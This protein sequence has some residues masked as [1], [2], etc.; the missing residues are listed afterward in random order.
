MTETGWLG[1]RTCPAVLEA[2]TSKV[3]VPTDS[4]SGHSRPLT[5]AS[6]GE[7][8]RGPSGACFRG[9][10][11]REAP[12]SRPD[13]FPK[14]PPDAVTLRHGLSLREPGGTS[15]QT[16]AAGCSLRRSSAAPR[17]S[18]GVCGG[19]RLP[20]AFPGL[21]SS[22]R[23]LRAGCALTAEAEAL[24]RA[25][26]ALRPHR[27]RPGLVSRPSLVTLP[28]RTWREASRPGGLPVSDGR[29]RGPQP[30]VAS[31]RDVPGCPGRRESEG[32]KGLPALVEEPPGLCGQEP[33][34]TLGPLCPSRPLAFCLRS[35]RHSL[36]LGCS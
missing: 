29:P 13:R 5:E 2:G 20:R 32:D 12:P 23:R 17:L 14:A 36:L 9:T 7:G 34:R 6:C 31:G 30:L 1:S 22:P 16:R 10:D 11:V 21:P 26:A 15:T 8:T 18:P 25:R 4:A 3:M 19:G 24:P 33:G 35:L 28:P 27:G